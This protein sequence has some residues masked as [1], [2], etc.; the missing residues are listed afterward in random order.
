MTLRRSIGFS[1]LDKY[2]THGLAILTT[3]VMARLLSPAETGVFILA[4][5]VIL[6]AENLRDFGMATYL[7][8]A[9][10]LE[11]STLRCAFTMTMGLSLLIL[12]AL[13]A[14]AGII[15]QFYQ[16]PELTPLLMIAMIGF[17]FTPFGTPAL[18]LLRR[19]MAFRTIAILN[20]TVAI[21]TAITTIL[22]AA[23]GFGALSYVWAYV[24][25]NVLL[26][27]MA[28]AVRPQIFV[29]WPSLDGI[30]PLLSFGLTSSAVLVANMAYELLP[31]L[32]FGKVLGLDA[33]GIFS[34]ATT[35]CQMPDRMIV[36][37]VQP[38]LLAAM[39]AR[40]RE[41]RG[42]KEAYLQALQL[43][44]ALQWPALVMLSLLADPV[45]AVLLGPQWSQTVPLVQVMALAMMALAPVFLTFP[46]LVASG[47]VQDT[48]WSSLI[49]LPP[50]ALLLAIVAPH[51]LGA[52]A[53]SLLVIAPLQM[54]IALQFIRKAIGLS[55]QELAMSVWQSAVVTLCTAGLP[56]AI[57]ATSATGFALDAVTTIAAIC[58]GAVGWGVGVALTRH[59][60]G[61]ALLPPAF[62]L[63]ARGPEGR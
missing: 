35:L 43:M 53:A 49:S 48:L 10:T 50:S 37:G 24:V 40:L 8:Q 11:R 14:S 4:Q 60:L 18:A 41:G 29:Y 45:V 42:L 25:A 59:P 7:V 19:E 58:G 28:F 34:R 61:Y 54:L 44:S 32:L 6:L 30:R 16:T 33:V 23:Q 57:V 20:I 13:L 5:A 9:P 2:V 3:A 12:L 36:S 46:T 63:R 62:G 17:I 27:L 51:G 26:S 22:L 56:L 15:A 47:R 55:W 1:M 39:S 52:V 31:R 38:V 21:V